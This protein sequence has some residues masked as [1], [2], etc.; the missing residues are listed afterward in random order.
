M[1][2]HRSCQEFG[3]VEE[4]TLLT[5]RRFLKRF[6]GFR[7]LRYFVRLICNTSWHHEMRTGS[8]SLVSNIK[9]QLLLYYTMCS[10]P[11]ISVFPKPKFLPAL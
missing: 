6:L 8:V 10:P 7:N 11:I 1:D 4:L 5:E 3:G 9:D 2:M